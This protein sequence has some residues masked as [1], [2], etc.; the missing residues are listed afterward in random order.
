MRPTSGTLAALLAAAT[1]PGCGRP[2]TPS[3]SSS[4]DARPADPADASRPV[5]ARLEQRPD[6]P[7]DDINP[8]PA[9]SGAD[10]PDDLRPSSAPAAEPGRGD[11]TKPPQ[12]R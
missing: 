3:R 5:R 10:V 11:P 1:I 6:E 9:P 12:R 2:A 4:A 7:D 8:C